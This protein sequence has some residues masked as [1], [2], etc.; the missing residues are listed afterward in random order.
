M[1]AVIVNHCNKDWL[2][3][4]YIGF[5]IFLVILGSV[6]AASLAGRHSNSIGQFLVGFY[7]RR[8]KRLVPAMASFTVVI[9]L[10]ICLADPE[11]RLAVIIGLFSLIGLFNPYLFS[12]LI[13]YFARAT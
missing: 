2:P 5:D 10:L 11:P 12:E 7:G 4:G 13:D 3:C 8:V 1:V 6:I 9:R